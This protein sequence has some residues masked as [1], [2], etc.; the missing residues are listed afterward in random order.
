MKATLETDPVLRDDTQRRQGELIADRIENVLPKLEELGEQARDGSIDLRDVGRRF[1]QI[2]KAAMRDDDARL[3]SNQRRSTGKRS[4]RDRSTSP[5]AAKPEISYS[6]LLRHVLDFQTMLLLDGMGRGTLADDR[7]SCNRT[8]ELSDW[9]AGLDQGHADSP[10]DVAR[11]ICAFRNDVLSGVLIDPS[12]IKSWLEGESGLAIDELA[13]WRAEGSFAPTEDGRCEAFWLHDEIWEPVQVPITDPLSSLAHL[14]ALAAN[15]APYGRVGQLGS[16]TVGECVA[17]ILSGQGLWR[18]VLQSEYVFGH[19]PTL[20][21]IVL[22]LYPGVLESDIIGAVRRELLA[23]GW[24]G[25]SGKGRPVRHGD[26]SSA[27]DSLW[28]ETAWLDY[29]VRGRKGSFRAFLNQVCESCMLHWLK[30]S[31]DAFRVNQSRYKRRV[32]RPG[33][34]LIASG[35]AARR[36][37]AELEE[38]VRVEQAQWHCRKMKEPEPI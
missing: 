6:G 24:E 30:K 36:A 33:F 17:Y 2:C 15:L 21:R 16:W 9:V 8:S 12:D 14:R 38:Q 7:A 11:D 3:Q 19:L 25:G 1:E 26:E 10:F 37:M 31:N 23:H 20:D 32:Q 18:P 5:P 27:I 13:T 22:I 34:G 29:Q 4:R 35:M 28:F